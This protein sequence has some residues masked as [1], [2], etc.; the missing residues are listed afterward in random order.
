MLKFNRDFFS[1]WTCLVLVLERPLLNSNGYS[2][3]GWGPYISTVTW[4]FQELEGH[5]HWV[6]WK[7]E[8]VRENSWRC[9]QDIR[10]KVIRSM[11]RQVLRLQKLKGR[12]CKRGGWE[13]CWNRNRQFWGKNVCL[14]VLYMRQTSWLR[15]WE[16][17]TKKSWHS[18]KK[19][20]S[21]K[22]GI[23]RQS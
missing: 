6:N 17:I 2:L 16:C 21:T 18:T 3:T 4:D 14:L 23:K 22:S 19:Q 1:H 7:Q 10:S 11:G 13:K 15:A 8:W 12:T 20:K 9:R 5:R